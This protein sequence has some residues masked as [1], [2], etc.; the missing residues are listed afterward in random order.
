MKILSLFLLCA[1]IT[2]NNAYTPS[3]VPRKAFS[4]DVKKSGSVES[5]DAGYERR[6]VKT[7]A[8][9]TAMAPVVYR[10]VE[11]DEEDSVGI[12]TGLIAC[13]VSLALGFSLGYGTL[14][15]S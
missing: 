10:A 6:R 11:E 8:I 13:V 14:E 5:S 4:T 9:A 15:I 7:A 2:T 1:F 3:S 12:G